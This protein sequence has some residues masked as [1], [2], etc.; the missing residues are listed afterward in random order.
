LFLKSHRLS[1]EVYDAMCC[2]GF[3]GKTVSLD[4]FKIKNTDVL[5]M[6]SNSIIILL[7]IAGERLF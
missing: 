5:F 4:Q 3:T 1:E 2:R 7:L 6:I